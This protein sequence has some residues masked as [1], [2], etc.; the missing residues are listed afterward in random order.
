MNPFVPLQGAIT[1]SQFLFD[2]DREVQRVFE[3]LNCGN[4]VVL[5]GEKEV[6]KSSVIKAIEQQAKQK[7]ILPRQTIYLNLATVKNEA[8]FYFYFCSQLDIEICK[9]MAL[10]RAINRKAT[11]ILLLIDEIDKMIWR[12]FSQHITHQLR[13]LAEGKNAPLQLIIATTISLE[14]MFPDLKRASLTSYFMGIFAEE[15]IKVWNKPTAYNFIISR[16]KNTAVVFTELEIEQL[17][18]Q[19]K[20]HPQKLMSLCHQTY[21]QYCQ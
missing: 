1:D 2:R 11:P 12:G 7:L 16:L 13:S 17:I 3:L 14:N 18:Q 19:S 6:G 8:D 5:I 15:S 10:K 20:G 9:G 21:Q 4:S